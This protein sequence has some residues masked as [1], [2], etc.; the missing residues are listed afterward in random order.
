VQITALKMNSIDRRNA[1]EMPFVCGS[2]LWDLILF[3]AHCISQHEKM[4]SIDRRKVDE[5]PFV[6]GSPL[7][8]LIPFDCH[9]EDAQHPWQSPLALILKM[10]AKGEYILSEDEGF[11]ANPSW[12]FNPFFQEIATSFTALTPR[13]DRLIDLLLTIYFLRLTDQ[14]HRHQSCPS[15]NPSSSS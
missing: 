13:N 6:Y 14:A 15:S 11:G 4:N 1:D 7:W 12:D 2:P 9:Y 10:Y 8:D 5:M 3:D